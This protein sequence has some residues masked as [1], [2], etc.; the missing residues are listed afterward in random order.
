MALGKNIKH[1]REL[2]GLARIDL[3]RAAGKDD[4]QP[5]Y[6]LEKRDSTKS[7]MAP[8]LAKFFGVDLEILTREDLTGLSL[9]EIK[10]LSSASSEEKE[11][12]RTLK[13]VPAPEIIDL[14]S[15]YEQATAEGR[16]QIMRMARKVEKEELPQVTL[17]RHS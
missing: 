6:A 9:E 12:A 4:D 2:K 5:I 13:L 11:K 3:A 14:I 1:L 17:V 15:L 7:D 16:K 8:D 10:A